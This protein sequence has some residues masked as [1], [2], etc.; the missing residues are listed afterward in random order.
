V[1]V[2]EQQED[3]GGGPLQMM[4]MECREEMREYVFDGR[5]PI[6]WHRIAH[7][8]RTS[9]SSSLPP[10]CSGTAPSIR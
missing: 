6:T 1:L 10:R 9:R 5:T 3:K 7:Y 4:R 2:H 8:T